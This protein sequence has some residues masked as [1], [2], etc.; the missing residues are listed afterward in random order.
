MKHPFDTSKNFFT[1]IAAHKKKIAVLLIA[2]MVL[3]YLTQTFLEH[4]EQKREEKAVE[5]A[6]QKV[7]DLQNEALDRFS[8]YVTQSDYDNGLKEINGLIQMDGSNPQYFLKRAGLYVLLDQ[9][10]LALDDLNTTLALSPDLYDALQLRSQIY[11]EK[12]EYESAIADYQ[13]MYEL[14]EWLSYMDQ[15]PALDDEILSFIEKEKSELIGDFCRGCGYCM[16]C[17]AGILINNCARMSLMV[18]RAPSKAW[19]NET[20]QENM[21]KIEGCLHCNQCMKKCPYQLNTP[22]LLKKN[23]E[24]YKKILAGEVQV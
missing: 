23:Y 10:D 20:W 21:K 2:V 11:D 6:A 22:E 17:P 4:Q 7:V 5:E 18:R 14:E 8:D 9:R 13:K 3:P 1:K 12:G 24:D 15:P 19:L 16:P